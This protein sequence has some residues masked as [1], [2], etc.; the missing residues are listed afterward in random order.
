MCVYVC[1]VGIGEKWVLSGHC[2][3]EMGVSGKV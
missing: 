3:E 2:T 1:V